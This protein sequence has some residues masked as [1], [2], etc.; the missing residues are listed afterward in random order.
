MY[1][2]SP[3]L[4]QDQ[5]AFEHEA[6]GLQAP[7]LLPWTM[8]SP[9][10]SSTNGIDPTPALWDNAGPVVGAQLPSQLPWL[11]PHGVGMGGS[12]Q[13]ISPPGPPIPT[14][15]IHYSTQQG[16]RN[17]AGRHHTMDRVPKNLFSDPRSHFSDA[18]IGFGGNLLPDFLPQ[19]PGAQNV[20]SAGWNQAA[21]SL[22]CG[23][24][25][26]SDPLISRLSDSDFAFNVDL[27]V[28]APLSNANSGTASTYAYKV[29]CV[30]G[31]GCQPIMSA[32]FDPRGAV[33]SG[34]TNQ[35]GI[36][37]FN[38]SDRLFELSGSDY[39]TSMAKAQLGCSSKG[40][41]P[42]KRVRTA[43]AMAR[44]RI[45]SQ[46]NKE[47]NRQEKV[48]ALLKELSE[49]IPQA[50]DILK[51]QLDSGQFRDE[52]QPKVNIPPESF[53]TW[54]DKM[55]EWKTY[56]NQLNNPGSDA[57][58][59]EGLKK[60]RDQSSEMSKLLAWSLSAEQS[61]GDTLMSSLHSLKSSLVRIHF[62]ARS[63]AHP[64]RR[65]RDSHTRGS[66]QTLQY[67]R[68]IDDTG[69]GLAPELPSAVE[70]CWQTL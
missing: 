20:L 27:T 12:H 38:G 68:S 37:P 11:L 31:E 33:T 43:Q 46:K 2:T 70:I 34:A 67:T 36:A 29:D 49:K 55:G 5:V 24:Q 28:T 18:D 60:V 58:T 42:T 64:N 14:T 22:N 1:P 47:R 19:G 21:Q 9:S 48:Q 15:S 66:T 45:T 35:G 26:L 44:N 32:S 62:A 65:S 10:L 59:L 63:L 8:F 41:T 4:S 61:C 6:N 40:R 13:N 25:G 30:T 23:P 50:F 57:K 16:L 54:L 69:Y 39:G 17:G 52:G 51:T 3:Q 7:S 56:L 53:E